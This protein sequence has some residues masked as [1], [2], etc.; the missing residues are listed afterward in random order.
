MTH[1]ERIKA[2]ISRQPADRCGLWLGAP[3]PE[4]TQQL[5]EFTNLADFEQVRRQYGDDFRWLAP[6]WNSYRHPEDKPM[7]FLPDTQGLPL[8]TPGP[9]ANIETVEEVNDFEFP[10]TAYLDFTSTLAQLREAGDVYRA[11]GMW[12]CFFHNIMNYFGLEEYFIKMH[13]HPEVVEAV[14]ERVFAFYYEANAHFFAQADN[15]MDALFMGN[16]LG[17]QRSLFLSRELLDRF[18]FPFLTQFI[19]QGRRAGYQIIVHSCGAITPLIPRLIAMGVD[20]LHPLQ[21]RAEGMDAESL[22]IYQDQIAF[23][24]GI[25]TQELLVRASPAEVRAEVQRVKSLL[26]PHL[27]ISPSHEGVLPNI[28]PCNMVALAEEAIMN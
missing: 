10:N 1:R 22:R 23:M 21:A 17:T 16:D 4:A 26:G 2:I 12:C 28:P 19:A 15:L 14:T 25:D 5:I 18:I 13:T 11:S 7:F 8:G 6:Q 9:L 3:V 27:I 20:A 24:G